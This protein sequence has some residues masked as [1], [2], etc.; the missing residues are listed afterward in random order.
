MSVREHVDKKQRILMGVYGSSMGISMT[1]LS[2]VAALE[3]F[4]LGY[5]VVNAPMYGEYLWHYRAFYIALLVVALAYIALNTFVKRDIEH[6]YNMLNVAN[7]VYAVFFFGWAMGITFFDAIIWGTV[8]SMVFM[9]FSLVVPLS[10]YIAPSVYAAIVVIADVLMI[11]LVVTVSGSIAPITNLSIFCIFQIVLGF[12]FLRLRLK[13]AE[14]I[15][16]EQENAD[17]DTLTGF[18]NRRVYDADMKRLAEQ[19]ESDLAYVSIDLNGLKEVNDHYGHE[20]GDKLIIGAA[21]C[22]ERCFGEKG[23]LYRIGGDEF[24]VL[25]PA[26]SDELENMFRGFDAGTRAWSEQNGMTLSTAYGYACYSELSDESE[27]VLARVAD[28]RMYDAKARYYQSGGA[29]RRRR[30]WED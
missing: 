3:V 16:E 5:S 10:F 24:V 13:L 8:D 2:I 6:R 27:A 17:I 26:G 1:A 14:R 11:Y 20:A 12:S 19:P 29:D 9:T 25:I 18:F 22:I 4:M 21:Q 23:N 28:K 7:P 15:I 30:S